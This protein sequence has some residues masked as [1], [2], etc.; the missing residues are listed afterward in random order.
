MRHEAHGVDA[1]YARR[2]LQLQIAVLLGTLQRSS[3]PGQRSYL[4]MYT[5][6][7][8]LTAGC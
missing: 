1:T 7:D 6:V 2:L 4:L 5:T 3:M 8:Y